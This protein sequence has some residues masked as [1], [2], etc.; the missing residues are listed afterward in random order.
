MKSGKF[1]LRHAAMDFEHY[2]QV[3]GYDTWAGIDERFGL[4]PKA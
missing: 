2:K 4:P 3:V 1:A